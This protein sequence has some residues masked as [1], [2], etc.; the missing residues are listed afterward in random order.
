M[1]LLRLPFFDE[2]DRAG[3]V[4]VAGCGGGY[5]VF[6]GLP[7]YFGLRDA[8][9]E[10]HLANLS[11]SLLPSGA[12]DRLTPALARVTALTPLT[13]NYFPEVHLA[14]WFRG[15]GEEVPIYCF[16]RCGARPLADAYRELLARL[17]IDTLILVDGGTDS[18]MRGDET[19]LGTPHEDIASIAAVDDLAVER[20]LL[21]CLGFGVDYF[22]G[23]CH[24]Q[25]LEAVAEIAKAGGY[26]G[27]FSLLNEMPEVRRFRRAAEAVFAA[28]PH[29]PSIV[30]TS[31][32]SALAGE[33]GDHHV[34]SRT[35]GSTLWI[36]PLMP[37]Y[38]T[39]RLEPVARRIVYLE[40]MKQTET[41]GDVLRL[42]ELF[43]HRLENIR[44][45]QDMMA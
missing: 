2:L 40:E 11:F 30:S 38:W 19:G 10:V 29:H 5:D 16:D 36:N 23:V 35:S 27:A 13:T 31:I 14:R 25:F 43:R 7:L 34:T 33:Y 32:L 39:F 45:W 4:L 41:Y 24:A 12:E 22:H 17:E 3:R 37:V 1:S 18:L 8:G 9:K 26:L 6:C 20:K 21:A 28:M 44:P 42:I 15:Q